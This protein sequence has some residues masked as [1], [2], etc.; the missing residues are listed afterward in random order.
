MTEQHKIKLHWN[1]NILR[2]VLVNEEFI[3]VEIITRHWLPGH[4]EDYIDKSEFER[5]TANMLGG[6]M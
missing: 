6:V 1:K 4:E 3:P 2:V 5:E